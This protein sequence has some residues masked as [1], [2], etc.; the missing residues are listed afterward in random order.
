M[1][2]AVP[3]TVVLKPLKDMQIVGK[4][5][6]RLNVADTA[7]GTKKFSADMKLPGLKTVVLAHSPVFGG[8]VAAFDA[9]KAS[10]IKGVAAVFKVSGLDKGAD[11][12]AIVADGYWP[13]KQARDVLTVQWDNTGLPL[14]DSAQ[15]L[16]QYR[17]LAAKRGG[18]R[19]D[20]NPQ[21]DARQQQ[22]R[23]FVGELK[24]P[25]PGAA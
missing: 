1:K 6:N 2:Q 14:P 9:S 13:A 11:A 10:A 25:A 19:R 12:V 22:A 4:P 24:D 21:T 17:E 23:A 18:N 7:R 16:A 8:K 15:L 20:F 5:Q 3:P